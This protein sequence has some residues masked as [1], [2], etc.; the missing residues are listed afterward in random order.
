MLSFSLC[1]CLCFCW[2]VRD[3]YSRNVKH[4]TSCNRGAEVE[5]VAHATYNAMKSEI[6][7]HSRG[8]VLST[9]GISWHTDI[10]SCLLTNRTLSRGTFK[11]SS[12]NSGSSFTSCN[13]GVISQGCQGP[14]S[15]YR[16]GTTANFWSG[17]NISANCLKIRIFYVIIWRQFGETNV[18]PLKFAVSRN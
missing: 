10:F 7:C 12:T 6:F 13:C 2:L 4:V 1:N 8:F 15:N 9:P 5:D 3:L 17:S 18:K 14:N 11:N 16:T